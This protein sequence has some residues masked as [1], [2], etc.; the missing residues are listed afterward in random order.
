MVLYC[1]VL[2]FARKL[3]LRCSSVPGPLTQ[4]NPCRVGQTPNSPLSLSLPTPES[5]PPPSSSSTFSAMRPQS[6]HP[7]PPSPP[8]ENAKE[9]VSAAGAELEALTPQSPQA[10]GLLAVCH[11][12]HVHCV[13]GVKWSQ[14]CIVASAKPCN[15]LDLP[16]HLPWAES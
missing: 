11:V 4:Q 1:T 3:L 10:F 5:L 9:P 12:F 8:P 13:Q 2:Y 6:S 7:R 14:C 15:L 16:G